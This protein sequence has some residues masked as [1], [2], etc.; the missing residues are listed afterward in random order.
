MVFPGCDRNETSIS[1]SAKNLFSEK[2]ACVAFSNG[3]LIWN[4]LVEPL[5]PPDYIQS[6][7]YLHRATSWFF[8][9][10]VTGARVENRMEGGKK[11]TSTRWQR[12]AS[13]AKS[14]TSKPTNDRT[15][16]IIGNRR[17]RLF[18]E[19]RMEKNKNLQVEKWEKE[20]IF[21][22]RCGNDDY[23]TSGRQYENIVRLIWAKQHNYSN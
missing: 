1:V 16:H 20:C 23:L 7:I 17:K 13:V 4:T 22:A 10:A 18:F 11:L 14:K 21:D 2:E 19:A 3:G 8:Q 9:G 12:R 6:W 5:V 15:K